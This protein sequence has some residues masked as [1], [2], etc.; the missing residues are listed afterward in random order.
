M[1][2]NLTIIF[3]DFS[4]VKNPLCATT[5]SRSHL[6]NRTKDRCDR[7]DLAALYPRMARPIINITMYNFINNPQMAVLSSIL[8]HIIFRLLIHL[9]RLKKKRL[10]LSLYSKLPDFR[11]YITIGQVLFTIFIT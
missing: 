3:I 4:P 6:P 10:F 9:I 7:L 2:H 8:S 1:S 11:N 5:S